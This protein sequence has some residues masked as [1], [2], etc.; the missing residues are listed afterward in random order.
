M[1]EGGAEFG[2]IDAH[3]KAHGFKLASHRYALVPKHGD[4]LYVKA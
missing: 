4:V 1:Y 3:M 2:Q